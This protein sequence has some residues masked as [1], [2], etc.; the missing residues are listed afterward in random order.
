MHIKILSGPR[1]ILRV[2]SGGRFLY[3]RKCGCSSS[4]RANSVIF[5]YSVLDNISYFRGIWFLFN[6]NN[7]HD[8]CSRV[9]FK[10]RFDLSERI[11]W[12]VPTP[13]F[14]FPLDM[15]KEPYFYCRI[16]F[17]FFWGGG[18][19]GGGWGGGQLCNLVMMMLLV[20]CERPIY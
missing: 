9:Y 16:F 6:V 4:H 5:L 14:I 1:K 13:W 7:H 12:A 18:G 2:L 3:V 17:F 11:I 20:R 15:K 19:G 10:M 8:A